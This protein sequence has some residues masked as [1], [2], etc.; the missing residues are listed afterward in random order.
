MQPEMNARLILPPDLERRRRD[1][2]R[3]I[4]NLI[5]ALAPEVLRQPDVQPEPTNRKPEPEPANRHE[6]RRQAA[7]SRG[8]R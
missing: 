6:R 2:E 3:S 1:E 8:K 5:A 7:L 4:E